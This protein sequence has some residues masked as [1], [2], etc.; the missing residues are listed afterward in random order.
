MWSLDEAGPEQVVRQAVEEALRIEISQ[1]VSEI[2]RKENS[3]DGSGISA[4][5]SQSILTTAVRCVRCSYDLLCVSARS[6]HTHK[7]IQDIIII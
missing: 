6:L 5:E 4:A 2:Q 7:H 1:R 3:K